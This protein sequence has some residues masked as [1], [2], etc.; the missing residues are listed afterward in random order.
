MRS[1]TR[2]A[3]TQ[4]SFHIRGERI[5]SDDNKGRIVWRC[6]EHDG[7]S[8]SLVEDRYGGELRAAELATAAAGC[9]Q[10][11]VGISDFSLVRRPSLDAMTTHVSEFADTGQ[12][13]QLQRSRILRPEGNT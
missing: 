2:Q 13:R 7:A 12:R 3:P 5:N 10:A 11:R 1:P 9:Q 6:N 4:K 8:D